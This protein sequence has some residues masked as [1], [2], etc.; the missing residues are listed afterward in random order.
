MKKSRGML[1]IVMAMMAGSIFS[2]S[3]SVNPVR[4]IAS[5][6]NTSH[7][8]RNKSKRPEGTRL[9]RLA[10]KHA[11]GV[12]HPQGLRTVADSNQPSGFRIVSYL[13]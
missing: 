10:A 7:R 1:G 3:Q 13:Y 5:N 11:I 2:P 9:Q 6:V 4:R 12:R 8:F